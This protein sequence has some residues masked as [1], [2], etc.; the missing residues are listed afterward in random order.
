M[1]RNLRGRLLVDGLTRHD[2]ESDQKLNWLW[3]RIIVAQTVNRAP[4][5]TRLARNIVWVRPT[6]H[7]DAPLRINFTSPS[8]KCYRLTNQSDEFSG[9][10]K[11]YHS[12]VNLEHFVFMKHARKWTFFR[13]NFQTM[14]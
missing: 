9:H 8:T 7:A 11:E 14:N 3:G 12:L 13:G 2:V 4:P 1:A 10:S 5:A 6:I